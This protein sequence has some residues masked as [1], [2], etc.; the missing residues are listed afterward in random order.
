LLFRMDEIFPNFYSDLGAAIIQDI[1]ETHELSESDVA[2]KQYT[3]QAWSMYV[4]KRLSLSDDFD[5]SHSIE[6]I[7]RSPSK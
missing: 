3:M 6:A 7:L 1:I 2:T 5:I 4:T